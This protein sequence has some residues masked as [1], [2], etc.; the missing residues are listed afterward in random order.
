MHLARHRAAAHGQAGR[1]GGLRRVGRVAAG[2]EVSGL[3]VE[4]L[5]SLKAQVDDRLHQIAQQMRS[6]KVGL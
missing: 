3:S 6:A 4:Q 1:R 5:L 2:V